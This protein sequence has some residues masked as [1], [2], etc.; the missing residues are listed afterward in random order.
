MG[1]DQINCSEKDQIL[2]KL[3]SLKLQNQGKNRT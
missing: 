1:R 2:P 3:A